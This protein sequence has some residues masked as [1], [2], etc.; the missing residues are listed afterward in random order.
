MAKKAKSASVSPSANTES[1]ANV[2]ESLVASLPTATPVAK[3]KA[4]KWQIPLDANEESIF[5]NWISA[6]IVSEPVMQR[7]ENSKDLLNQIC[8]KEFCQRFFELRSRPSNPQLQTTKNGNVD[9][10]ASWLF[11][12]KFKVK[13]PEVT[14]GID[15]KKVYTTAFTD[16]GLHPADAENLVNNEL[17]L[18]PVIGVRPITE[19]L[20][21]HYGSSREFVPASEVEKSAGKKLA[22]FLSGSGKVTLD[23]LTNEEKVALIQRDSG[24]T[25][26]NGFLERVCTYCK[27]AEQLYAI[28]GLLQP[29]VYPSYAKFAVNDN[30]VEQGN[31]K[32][33]AA[34][35]ILGTQA[36]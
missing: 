3:G 9:H 1:V 11:T 12:D 5:A 17:I 24:V 20:T 32:I 36:D 4:P 6:K 7:L 15:P 33:A 25:V 10:T 19:L 8:L 34:A 31:R 29:V 2:L 23:A 22:A 27:S 26:R 14:E 30:P 13:L 18:N 35:D 16:V 21:G 28:F